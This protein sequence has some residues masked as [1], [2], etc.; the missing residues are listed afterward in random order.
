M[1]TRFKLPE[2]CLENLY[3]LSYSSFSSF[4]TKS[5]YFLIP[6]HLILLTNRSPSRDYFSCSIFL[7]DFWILARYTLVLSNL[8]TLL[9]HLFIAEST[10]VSLIEACIAE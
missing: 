8:T 5:I 6:L 2:L 10:Q 4:E 1:L 7:I 9:V 3:L